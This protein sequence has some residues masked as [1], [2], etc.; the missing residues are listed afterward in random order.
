MIIYQG[1]LD[2][3]CD[4]AGEFSVESIR[5]LSMRLAVIL[6]SYATFSVS[7]GGSGGRLFLDFKVYLARLTVR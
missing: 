4:N 5:L 6:T 1:Q 7:G 3:I 2:L